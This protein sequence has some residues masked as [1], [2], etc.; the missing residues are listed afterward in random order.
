MSSKYQ[1]LDNR[2]IDQWKVT[3]LKEEL[4][5]RKLT[6]RGLKEELVKRLD[7]A[8]RIERENAAKDADNGFNSEPQ[9]VE[10]GSTEEAVPVAVETVK[11]VLDHDDSGIEKGSG[12]KVQVDINDSAAAL[13]PGVVQGRDIPVEEEPII[14]ITTVQTEITVSETLVSDIALTGQDLQSSGQEENVNSNIPVEHEGPKPKIENEGPKPEAGNEGQKPDVGSEGQKP[15]VENDTSKSQVESMGSKPQLESDDA[16]PQLETIGSKPQLEND[17]L[18]PQLENAGLKAPHEDGMH[19]SSAPTNQVSEEDVLESKQIDSKFSTEEMG[20]KSEKNEEPVVKEDSPVDVVGDGVSA[21]KKDVFIEN[22]SHSAVPSEKRKLHD[23]E[24]VVNNEPAKRR[25][26]NTDNVKVPERQGPNL[27]PTTTPKE[28]IQPAALRRNFSRSDSTASD[29]TPK[30]RVVPPSQK[31]ATT[32]LRIDRFLRPF[33]LKAVQELLGKT[34]TVTSFWMDHIKTHCYVTYSSVEEAMETRN[35]VYNLQ[36]PPNGGRLLVADF[37]DP[38]EVKM[39]LEAPPKTPTTPGTSGPTAPQVQPQPQPSPR[40]QISRQQ[41]PPPSLPPPPPLSNPPSVRERLPPPPP[42]PEKLDPPIVT[43]DD[44]FRKTKATPRIYYL[45]LSEEQVAAKR[46]ARGRYTKQCHHRGYKTLPSKIGRYL[47]VKKPSAAEARN[48]AQN[49]NENGVRQE[50]GKLII[51]SNNCPPLRKSEIEYYAMLCKVGVHHYNGNNNDLGTACG[52]YFRVSCLSVIDPALSHWCIFHRSK[53]EL[54]VATWDKQFHSSQMVQKVPLLY[55]ANDILQNSKRKG[56]EFVNEFW[57]VLPGALKDLLENGD[58]RGKNVVSRLVGIWEERR[59]FGSRARSLK[60][61]MLGEEVP[62]PL[63]LSKK[64]PRSTSVRIVKRDSRSI[65]TKLSIGGTAEKIVSAFHLVLGEQPNEDE[66]TSKCKSAVHRVK[67]M[68]KDVDIACAT[69]KDPKRKTLAKELEDEENILKECIEKLKSVE[70]SRAA[71]VLQLKEALREQES[72]LE[73]VRTQMQVA[74]AQA[75]EACNMRKL[76]ND[77]DYVSTSATLDANAKAGETPKRTAAAIAAEVADKLAASSSSQMIMHSVLSTFAAEEAKNA[78][79][80]NSLTSVPVNSVTDAVSKSEKS[81][82]VAD[83]NAFVPAQALAPPINHSYQSVM[84]PQ[85]A[86]QNQTTTSQAQYHMLPNMASQQYLQPSG[87]TVNPYGSYGGMPPLPPGP[88]PPPPY[89]VSPMVPLTPQALPITQQQ[90]VPAAQQTTPMTQQQ[91]L[92]LTQPPVPP[93]FRPLQP[94]GMVYYGHPPHSYGFLFVSV[95][96]CSLNREES[97]STSFSVL[98]VGEGWMSDAS[99]MTEEALSIEKVASPEEPP[100]LPAQGLPELPTLVREAPLPELR[101]TELPAPKLRRREGPPELPTLG[102]E[103]PPLE[104][105]P[106]ELPAP[107]L[108]RRQGPPELPTLGWEAP[109]PELRQ[110]EGPPELPTAGQREAP[111]QVFILQG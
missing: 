103:A 40:Q 23:Q 58:D 37:V 63:E 68:E 9:P 56:N 48:S 96:S 74:H 25:R 76:L 5:K 35:A 2:P 106:T 86:M 108:R 12:V 45:P 101:P 70:A 4:K 33:T 80:K 57:K 90:P 50:N 21:D 22:K 102:R 85:P 73:N 104:L 88:P 61:V 44:L 34:G 53:A 47:S 75:E 59:V 27:T 41:L 43:L 36:W 64:R 98:F 66:E 32:S 39:R 72:E 29:D 67:K 100:E 42:P 82:P 13:G 14:Q 93:S 46:A 8:V 81:V 30:E 20:E 94:P 91:L 17:D 3:E 79:L 6:T 26:W 31:P 55:L 18:K 84:V 71:L 69:A 15:E 107:E 10:V 49:I 65:K 97:S 110:N 95:Q 52:K 11:D 78:G 38:Q 51:I 62:P 7:E 99:F 77:E 111:P 28:T 54:V 60:D 1:I 87:G 105:R 16:E 24:A 89:M 92:P 109:P 83:P 19:D